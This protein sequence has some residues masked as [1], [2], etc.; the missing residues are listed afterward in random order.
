MKKV[1]ILIVII[2]TIFIGLNSRDNRIDYVSLGD[3]LSLG[4]NE[5][6]YVSIGYSDYVKEYLE[7]NN[8]LKT[9]TKEFSDKDA[10]ITDIINKINNNEQEDNVSIQ[11]VISN[12]DLLTI[13]VGLNEILYK[14]NNTNKAYLYDY[15]D[16]YINDMKKLIKLIKKY[17]NKTIFVIGYYNPTN[18]KDLDKYIIYSNDKLISICSEE[19]VNYVNI[20]NIFKNNNKLIYNINNYYP[21][22]EGYKLISNEIIKKLK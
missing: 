13:S 5:N 15:I 7:S 8:K 4:I 18:Y 21:N 2:L 17:N 1:I 10:R 11:N 20:Y 19:N 9:Y 6:N 3:G 14:Y 22:K 12:A 16:S